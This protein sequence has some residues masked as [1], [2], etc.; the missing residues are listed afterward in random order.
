MKK[1]FFINDTLENKISYYLLACF[2]IALPYQH[3]FS[4][5]LLSCFAI[6]TLIHLRKARLPMLKNKTVWIISSIF[7]LNLITISYSN[8]TSEG[9]KDVDHQLGILLFPVCLSITN[10]N[11]NKYKLSLLKIFAFTCTFTIIYLFVDAF[12]IIHYFHLPYSSFLSR[13]FI[14]QSFSAPIGLHA[15]Y[16]SMY[17]ALSISLFLYLFFCDRKINNWRYIFFAGILSAGLI[18]LSSRA[19]FISMC[20]IIIIA[21]PTLLLYG[22][23]KLRFFLISFLA[24]LLIAF[25]ITS[26]GSLKKRYISD[27]ETD[28]SENGIT[29]DHSETR[30][31]RWNLEWE[32]ILKSPVIGYG[33][34]SEKYVLKNNYFEKKF[35]ISYLLRLNAHNQYLS[36]LLNTGIIGLL[37]YLYILY[38]GF[39]SAIKR[40]DFLQL[41]FMI[42]IAVVSVSEN[43]LDVNKGI[44]F[45]SFFFSLFALSIPKEN[46][47]V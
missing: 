1:L 43:I 45:Y 20:I 12:R 40:K 9:F 36:F 23:K 47:T 46:I 6:H 25:T 27:L 4:E 39:S 37:L 31:K 21:V 13:T 22:K 28:L 18:Q 30:M 35:Y 34:G 29:P 38:Y 5:I 14:N 24:F 15:T 8:Y 7:F 32:I 11:L 3:F 44:F 19:V 33:S 2:L 41:S 26:V 17:V 42:L 16:L 10:L